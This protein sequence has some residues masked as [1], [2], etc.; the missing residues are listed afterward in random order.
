[1]S[2]KPCS[3][4][5][6]VILCQRIPDVPWST[7]HSSITLASR[8]HVPHRR[9]VPSPATGVVIR[10]AFKSHLHRR[11]AHHFLNAGLIHRELRQMLFGLSMS[12]CH[13]SKLLPHLL[14]D[15][16]RC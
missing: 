6:A 12:R 5:C 14:K 3:R 7:L 9:R 8:E 1:M 13:L 15:T 2:V 16:A 4:I 11:I 10:R